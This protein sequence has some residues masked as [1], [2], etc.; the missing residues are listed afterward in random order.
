MVS[1]TGHVLGGGV[2]AQ[3][4]VG[5]L[6]YLVHVVVEMHQRDVA[7]TVIVQHGTEIQL[8]KVWI[9]IMIENG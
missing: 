7:K 5:V 1:G 4:R 9:E 3:N 6:L 8:D 2:I